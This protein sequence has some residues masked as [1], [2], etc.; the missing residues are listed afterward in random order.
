LDFSTKILYVLREFGV[1]TPET[2]MLARDSEKSRFSETFI[3]MAHRR[4]IPGEIFARRIEDGTA[5]EL[6]DD[7]WKS[8]VAALVDWNAD[9]MINI[10][11][12]EYY[13]TPQKSADL[14]LII[15][16]K[17][18][19]F[20]VAVRTLYLARLGKKPAEDGPHR[21]VFQ[22]GQDLRDTLYVYVR[23]FR[24]GQRAGSAKDCSLS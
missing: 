11:G 6:I 2:I 13:Y 8:Y 24:K 9:V 18:V 17:F 21:T 22:I 10:V 23:C 5:A 19:E 4:I 1:T 14:E 12:M 15:L 7:A 20:D 3:R 16:P